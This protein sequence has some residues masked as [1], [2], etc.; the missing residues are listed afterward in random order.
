MVSLYCM[1]GLLVVV[2]NIWRTFHVNST[3]GNIFDIK[4]KSVLCFLHHGWHLFTAD[5]AFNRSQ[6][7]WTTFSQMVE[8]LKG[9]KLFKLTLIKE[10]KACQDMCSLSVAL[11]CIHP[12]RRCAPASWLLH[13][14]VGLGIM[15]HSSNKGN[16]TFVLV[17]E[18]HVTTHL[19]KVHTFI[20]GV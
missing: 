9:F 12:Q 6:T 3:F 2:T 13:K 10:Y 7:N 19:S 8:S 14:H 1:Y 20:S 15:L 4:E 11:H 5:W 18:V 16:M 17:R